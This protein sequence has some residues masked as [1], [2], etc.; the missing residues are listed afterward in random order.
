MKAYNKTRRHE[1]KCPRKWDL[2]QGKNEQGRSVVSVV[3]WSYTYVSR[4]LKLTPKML[5]KVPHTWVKGMREKAI[6]NI[7]ASGHSTPWL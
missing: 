6:T 1:T 3:I 7:C 4:G 2:L 5:L